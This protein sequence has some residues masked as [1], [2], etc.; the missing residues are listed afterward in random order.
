M[1]A[2]LLIVLAAVSWGGDAFGVWQLNAARS[3]L[4]ANQKTMS[5]RIDP[6][7]RGE[8]FTLE[9]ATWDGR[10]STSSTILYFDGKAR[11]FEDSTCVGTQWSQHVDGRT[12]EIVRECAGGRRV[13]LIRRTESSSVLVLEITEEN[14]DGRRSERR[15]VLERR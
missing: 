8:V 1:R 2:A 15:V 6:H 5:V 12:A 11:D 14:A 7:L 9:T 3:T 4:A 10:A 13:R